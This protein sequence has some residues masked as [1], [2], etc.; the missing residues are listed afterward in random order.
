R[1]DVFIALGEPLGDGS[2]SIRVQYKPL[3]RFIWFGAL[4][5]AFGGLLAVSDRRYRGNQQTG[6]DPVGDSAATS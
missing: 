1:R 6:F 2:W 3:I 4:I 5:M